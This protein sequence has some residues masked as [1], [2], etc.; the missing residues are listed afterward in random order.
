MGRS[1]GEPSMSDVIVSYKGFDANWQCRGYQFEV[2]KT[3]EHQGEVKACSGGFHACEH[4]LNVFAYYAP[5][6]SRFAVVEQSGDLSRHDDTKVASRR[7]TIKA[8]IGIPGL[9]KAAIE[10][11]TSRCKPVDPESPA[12]A[13]GDQGAASATGDQGAASAT[14]TWGAASATGTW[15]AASATGYQGAASA[16]GD[17]GAASAT[18]DQGAASATGYQG[19]ASATGYQGAASAT[20]YQGAAS[21]TGYQGAASATGYQG[22]ASATG[23]WGAASATGD[24]GAASATG[25][26]GAAS[27]TGTWGAASA[28]GD[29]GAASA[30]GDQG[31]AM[32][33]GYEGKVSGADGNALFLVERDDDYNIVAVWAG[34]AGR[35]G[36]EPDTF[37]TLRDG[38]PMSL[39]TSGNLKEP[40]HGT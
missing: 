12:S 39:A 35:D 8:E 38:K 19:A 24:Q 7:I 15:G 40:P 10:Y 37:Y 32:A 29:Q 5:A 36:I 34:I 18:G 11:V 22:A 21:A 13:T 3:Y 27:A 9:V 1:E 4:P 26:Q 31:A 17:Q 25:D 28:T 33:S 30:T 2:G 14:G 23:T 16:T 20:G 6:L